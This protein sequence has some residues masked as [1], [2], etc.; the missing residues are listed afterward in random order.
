VVIRTG[1]D[2]YE[3]VDGNHRIHTWQEQGFDV[4]PVWV[5]DKY[6]RAAYANRAAQA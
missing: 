3:V 1:F 4:I 5:Y 2:T 6:L